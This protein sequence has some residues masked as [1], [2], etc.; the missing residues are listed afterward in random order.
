MVIELAQRAAEP[1]LSR[2]AD[3]IAWIDAVK[4]VAIV[5]VVAGHVWRGL[6]VADLIEDDAL[7][8]VVDQAIYLFHMDV[9]F[10]VSGYVA[11]MFQRN[12]SVVRLA[13]RIAYPLLLWTYL[14]LTVKQALSGMVNQPPGLE[15]R[16]LPLPPVD[17]FWFLW[18]LLLLSFAGFAVMRIARSSEHIVPAALACIFIAIAGTRTGVGAGAWFGPA[19]SYA[20]SYF[21][22]MALAAAGIARTGVRVMVL[23]AGVF[24]GCQAANLWLVAGSPPPL[25]LSLACAL[26]FIAMVAGGP[27]A[28]LRDATAGVAARSLGRLSLPIF[29][30]HV[31]AQA[32]TRIALV[33]A[34]VHDL[35]THVV[36]GVVCG[37]GVPVVFAIIVD[38][39]GAR[40]LMGF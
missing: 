2:D 39:V 1:D 25:P 37:V 12:R 8:R 21:L 33:Q 4:G 24:L 5:L 17:H 16:F 23:G 6:Q 26:G 13:S 14:Y 3:R 35:A 28:L 34:G 15:F 9:F 30:T 19:L 10:L 31:F 38:R 29:L 11:F 36:L 7:F 32:G 22:G 20:P 18:A 27:S 40:R